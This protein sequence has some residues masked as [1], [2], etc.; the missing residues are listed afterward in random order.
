VAHSNKSSETNIEVEAEAEGDNDDSSD[1][2]HLDRSYYSCSRDKAFLLGEA[3]GASSLFFGHSQDVA[4][5]ATT[6]TFQIRDCMY[7][8][9]RSYNLVHDHA[10]RREDERNLLWFTYRCDFPELAPY[11]YTSDAG[12]GCMLRAS[13]MLLAQA[14]RMHYRGREFW[15]PRTAVN[16]KEVL[17]PNEKFHAD[18][19]TWFA[20]HP[21]F[22]T[23]FSFHNMVAC[24]LR[25][26]KLPGMILI[27]SIIAGRKNLSLFF[28]FT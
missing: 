4:A 12:W 3:D 16:P 2:N 11:G 25:Y 6:S 23:S 27:V 17:R 19:L 26:D 28:V 13:Q 9:G 10:A 20:D 1:S 15:L 21:G 22:D 8:L 7:L 24:G 14:L 5:A 18:L